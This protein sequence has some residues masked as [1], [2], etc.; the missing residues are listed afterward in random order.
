MLNSHVGY[1]GIDKQARKNHLHRY[2]TRKKSLWLHLSSYF[3]IVLIIL[4]YLCLLTYLSMYMQN[5]FEVFLKYY[6]FCNELVEFLCMLGLQVGNLSL[7][8]KYFLF[9]H[10]YWNRFS[11]TIHTYNL[12]FPLIHFSQ[13]FLTFP[14]L[15]VHSPFVSF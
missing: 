9:K 15:Q 5:M 6:I 1:L 10:F 2:I 14:I 4:W 8:F 11:L 13:L 7:G 12:R 3:P